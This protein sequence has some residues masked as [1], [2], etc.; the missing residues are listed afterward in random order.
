MNL[1]E[2]IKYLRIKNNL[3]SKELSEILNISV[4]SVSLYE[5]GKRTPSLS[6]II[7]VADYFNV[8]TDYLLGKTNIP[9][10]FCTL[11]SKIDYAVQLQNIINTFDEG[12]NIL[13]FNGYLMNE[14]FKKVLKKTL[15]HVTDTMNILSDGLKSI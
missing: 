14:Q 6:L 1:N 12:D 2:R 11:N 8:S 4:S 13:L 3:T 15:I 7:K 10:Q 5:S 9:N